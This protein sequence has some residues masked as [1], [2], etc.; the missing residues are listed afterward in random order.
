[1]NLY[2]LM[3]NRRSTRE[4]SNESFPKDKLKRVLKASLLSPS[5][6]D[7]KPFTYL[8]IDDI[9]TK[10]IIKKTCES[11]D[12][13][14]YSK[15]PE[16]FKEWMQKKNISLEK[17]FLVDAP[18]LVVVSGEVNKPYWLESTWLSIAYFVLAA[19]NEGLGTLTYTPA[20]IDFLV[21]LLDIPDGFQP[22]VILPIGLAEGK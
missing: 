22:V 14:Y 12:K 15:S 19:E 16:W 20:E 4:F 1:M 7:Q 18:Y 10:E 17:D 21:E 9:K 2:K 3:E 6:A 8:V 11:I 13:K 5:G